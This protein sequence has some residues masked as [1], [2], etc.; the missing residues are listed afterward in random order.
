MPTTSFPRFDPGRPLSRDSGTYVIVL[1]MYCKSRIVVG[2]LGGTLFHPGYYLYVGSA[3]GPGGLGARIKHHTRLSTRPHWHIDY[4]RAR[5][6]FIEAWYL[7]GKTCGEHEL[8]DFIASVRG[9]SP[10][11]PGFGSSDCR[12]RTHFFFSSSRP[13]SDSLTRLLGHRSAD[14][15]RHQVSVWS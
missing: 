4:L 5:T 9:I 12:C 15:P 13:G 8:A 11:V 1:E 7:R 2:A 14:V 3:F 10:A 6:D